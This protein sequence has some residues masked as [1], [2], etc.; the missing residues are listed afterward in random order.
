MS[1]IDS[2]LPTQDVTDGVTGSPVPSVSTQ[3]AGSDGTNLRTLSTDS[4][5]KLISKVQLQ[6]NTGTAITLGQKAMSA[7]VPIVIASDQTAIPI[8]RLDTS[9]ANGSIAA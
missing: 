2:N 1:D 3:I 5:G 8:S 7:S 4:T 6:D 9:P